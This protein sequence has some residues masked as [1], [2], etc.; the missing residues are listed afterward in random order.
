MSA[1]AL[2]AFCFFS[3]LARDMLSLRAGGWCHRGPARAARHARQ[4]T[5]LLL[6]PYPLLWSACRYRHCCCCCCCGALSLESLRLCL[7]QENLQQAMVS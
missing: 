4:P 5:L 6:L 7:S 2:L 1:R 3:M